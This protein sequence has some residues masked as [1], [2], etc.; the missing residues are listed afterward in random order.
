MVVVCR[1]KG[2]YFLQQVA[3][4]KENLTRDY[5]AITRAV[6]SIAEFA[7]Y[8]DFAWS[9]MMVASRNFGINIDGRKTDALVPYAGACH[10]DSSA[11]EACGCISRRAFII[12][13]AFII[14]RACASFVASCRHVESPAAAADALGVRQP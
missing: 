2:S 13:R 5:E 6:P 14:D 8:H 12:G 11:S 3:D 10:R 4:R 9:R 1:L 7:S